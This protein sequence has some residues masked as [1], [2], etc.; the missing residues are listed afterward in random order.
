MT[1]RNALQKYANYF[2]LDDSQVAFIEEVYRQ[3]RLYSLSEH[4]TRVFL[5]DIALKFNKGTL[6]KVLTS[7]SKKFRKKK[8]SQV[9]EYFHEYGLYYLN[10][11]PLDRQILLILQALMG[12]TQLATKDIENLKA[13]LQYYFQE[14]TVIDHNRPHQIINYV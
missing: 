7:L 10:K 11:F 14:A 5:V 3:L 2:C 1:F 8:D 6:I 4:L 9:P 13:I 12:V